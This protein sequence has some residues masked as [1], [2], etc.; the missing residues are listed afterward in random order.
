[1]SA[2][3]SCVL[4]S[5]LELVHGVGNADLDHLVDELRG[6]HDCAQILQDQTST[7]V[8]YDRYT[9]HDA[10]MCIM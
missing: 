9:I 3:S 8:S 10:S 5:L 4:T 1:M 7:C 6:D 2:S